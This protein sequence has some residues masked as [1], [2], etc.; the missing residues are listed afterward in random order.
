MKKYQFHKKWGEK[1]QIQ[2]EAIDC[3]YALID[4]PVKQI[5]Y[6]QYL[7]KV[8][9]WWD[10]NDIENI[11]M[12]IRKECKTAERREKAEQTYK[13][14]L[15]EHNRGIIRHNPL[16]NK[17]AKN[18]TK[19][20]QWFFHGRETGRDLSRAKGIGYFQ[21]YMQQKYIRSKGRPVLLA[22][23]LHHLIDYCHELHE[24]FLLAEIIKRNQERI[25]P[26]CLSDYDEIVSF[27]QQN[28]EELKYDFESY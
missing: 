22:W 4:E 15:S 12:N 25:K 28:W 11:P 10:D 18:K 26:I 20:Q 23:Y 3:A 1:C 5:E 16:F 8:T 7:T 17:Q 14:Y 27:V 24:T 2:S 13:K 21:S 19:L 9:E 6:L